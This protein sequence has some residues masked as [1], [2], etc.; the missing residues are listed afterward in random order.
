[1]EEA[2]PDEVENTYAD[3]QAMTFE[4]CKMMVKHAQEMVLKSSS[5][6]KELVGTS[7]EVT[8]T[9]SQLVESARGAQATVESAEVR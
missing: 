2:L 9:Y 7:R 8:T 4:H 3:Y 5:A 1:M 6:P